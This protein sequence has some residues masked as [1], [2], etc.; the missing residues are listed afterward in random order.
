MT[1]RRADA[2]AWANSIRIIYPETFGI[3]ACDDPADVYDS[4]FRRWMRLRPIHLCQLRE[5]ARRQAAESRQA[6]S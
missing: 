6:Q 4:V 3:A 2:H 5:L 1:S